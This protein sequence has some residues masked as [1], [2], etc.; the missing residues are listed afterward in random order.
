MLINDTTNLNSFSTESK[1]PNEFYS[2]SRQPKCDATKPETVWNPWG[3]GLMQENF[4]IPIIFLSAKED[5]EKVVNCSEKFNAKLEGQAGRPLCSIEINS[6][7]AAA[8]NSEVCIRRSKFAGFIRSMRFC[9]PLQSRNVY[10]TLFPREIV[11]PTN[12][13]NDN[14]EKIILISARIDTTSMFDGVYPGAMDSLA[15]I[16]T[17]VSTAHY[18]RKIIPNNVYEKNK[19]N[20]LFMLFNG[21]SFDYIGSQRFVYDL[22]KSAFPAPSSYSRPL[23]LDNIYMMIDLDA[24]DTFDKLSIYHRSESVPSTMASKLQQSIGEYINSLSLNVTITSEGTDAIPPVSAQMFL[25]ENASFPALIV[26]AERPENKFY[27]SIYDDA[28]NLNY[29]YHNSSVSFDQLDTVGENNNFSDTSIQVKIRNIATALSLGIHDI[30][31][32]EKEKYTGNNIASAALVD[33][34]IYCYLISTKCKLFQASFDQHDD[35][36]AFAPPLQR[37]VSVNSPQSVETVGWTYRML[38]FVLS[39]KVEKAKENCNTL[40]YYWLP[41]STKTGECRYTTQN[42]SIAVSPAFEDDENYN[43]SSNLYSTWTEST[44]NDLSARIFLRPSASHEYFT[45][46]IGFVVLIFSFTM[47]YVVNSKAELLFGDAVIAE[48]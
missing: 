2:Y 29:V 35:H 45:L 24:I 26:A 34:L 7:M 33:E 1:C 13:S 32:N 39:E 41:G 12:R 37:Y 36:R 44:W 30:L 31:V 11:P 43:F 15:S 18:L 20:V 23:T 16:A 5:Y 47:V 4:D 19:L 8:S 46:I 10:G 48:Q 17:L 9:D 22:K 38:G 42:F 40:P 6:F 14:D 27:H 3:S 25:R 28:S 21:E